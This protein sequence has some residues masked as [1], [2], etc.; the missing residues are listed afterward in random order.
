M[1]EIVL[2]IIYIAKKNLNKNGMNFDELL[3]KMPI[4]DFIECICNDK[5]IISL[6][7]ESHCFRD[8]ADYLKQLKEQN[9]G[10]IISGITDLDIESSKRPRFNS[11]NMSTDE[12]QTIFKAI[13]SNLELYERL[14]RDKIYKLETTLNRTILLNIGRAKVFHLLGFNLIDWQRNYRREILSVMPEMRMVID[15]NYASMCN[16]DDARLFGVLYDILNREEDIIN[17]ILDGKIS[18]KS[19]PLQKIKTKNYAFERLGLIEKPTGVVFYDKDKDPNNTKLK[20]GIMLLRDV[21]RDYNLNWIFN[22]YMDDRTISRISVSGNRKYKVKNA[23]TL[24]VE[25]EYSDRLS[26]QLASITTGIGSI[27]KKDFD[28]NISLL[29][30]EPVEPFSDEEIFRMAGKI[31]AY[32]PELNL[33]HLQEFLE[34]NYYGKNPKGKK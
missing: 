1:D 16:N 14:Y 17:A 33:A 22:G 34:N 28:Y 32:F 27:R 15:D 12:M 19:F 23:S 25:P 13:E 4:E 30:D 5:E 31:V 10:K 26:N 24:L 20:S 6:I 9:K 3:D 11:N 18:D 29:E 2:K 8:F 21:I 7:D